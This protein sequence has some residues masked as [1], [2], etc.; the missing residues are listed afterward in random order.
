MHTKPASDRVK[1][2][3]KKVLNRGVFYNDKIAETT[4]FDCSAGRTNSAMDVWGFEA[5][6]LVSVASPFDRR[7]KAYLQVHTYSRSELVRAFEQG[8][9]INLEEKGV[10]PQKWFRVLNRTD[11]GYNK[12]MVIA[13]HR[14]IYA[15]FLN[16]VVPIT[17]KLVRQLVLPDIGSA[18]FKV[19]Y[20]KNK[21]SFEFTSY[22]WGHG[23]GLSQEGARYLAQE[24]G[25]NY[26]QIIKYYFP[27]TKVKKIYS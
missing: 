11:G 17:G 10:P 24:K 8:F 13:G 19:K 1:R 12:E 14:K 9:G 26:V 5:P 22:G 27:G 15:G 3:V 25:Y 4:C 18:K 16:K 23:V 6:Y 20:I 21:D 7:A 2:I